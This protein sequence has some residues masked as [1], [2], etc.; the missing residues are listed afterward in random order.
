MGWVKRK[1]TGWFF[2]DYITK[3][4]KPSVEWTLKLFDGKK[5]I[6][7]LIAFG[8]A[9]YAKANQGSAAGIVINQILEFLSNS[10]GIE[11][12]IEGVSTTAIIGIVVGLYDKLRKWAG[13]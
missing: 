12:S 1:I 11:A 7:S 5:T 13:G 6:L 8:L 2:K 9:Q 4:I 10:Y 3:Y